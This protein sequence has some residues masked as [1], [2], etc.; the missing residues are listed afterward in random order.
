[1]MWIP[2][3]TASALIVTVGACLLVAFVKD[4]YPRVGYWLFVAALLVA[5]A[6]FWV[7]HDM[8]LVD[9]EERNLVLSGQAEWVVF[10]HA[11]GSQPSIIFHR[12]AEKK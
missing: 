12:K 3:Y 2:L 7:G 4:G 6:V 8:Q 9:R 11:D 10:Q 5:G 1:M